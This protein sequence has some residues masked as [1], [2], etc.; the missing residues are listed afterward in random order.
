MK[1]L[2]VLMALACVSCSRLEAAPDPEVERWEKTAAR[3]TITRDDWGIAH[4]N[5]K[6]DADVV[7]G[8]PGSPGVKRVRAIYQVRRG[9]VP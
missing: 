4:I 5:A 1:K 7:F 3:V 8:L 6:T 2:A 9:V